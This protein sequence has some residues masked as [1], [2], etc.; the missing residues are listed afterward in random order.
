MSS[1]GASYEG[2]IAADH[3][4]HSKVTGR[5]AARPPACF[6][7]QA[8]SAGATKPSDAIRER[9]EGGE[10]ER[11]A[12]M[13]LACNLHVSHDDRKRLVAALD[14]PDQE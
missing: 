8:A 11:K 13:R 3:P 6:N 9:A 4:Q 12:R 7:R 1:V 5:R 10:G 2:R 14:S